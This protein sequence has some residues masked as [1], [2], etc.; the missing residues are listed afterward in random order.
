M[1]MWSE[2][3]L[4]DSEANLVRYVF[5]LDHGERFHPE[6]RPPA[7]F[8]GHILRTLQPIVIHTA[9]E[10][11]RRMAELDATNIGG[12]TV[13]NSCIYVPILRGDAANG[14]ITVGKQQAHAF[15]DSDVSLLTT[16]G[17]AMSVALENARLFDETQR[18][19]K[20]TEQRAAELAVINSI[21]EGMAA[22]LNFQAIVDL[23]GDKLR[24][25]FHTGDIGIRW[26]DAKANLIHYLYQY[27]HGVRD[28]QPPRTPSA[29]ALKILQTRQPV[30]INNPAEYAALGFG[31]TPGTDQSLSSV[32]VPILGS[33]RALGSIALENYE[34]ENAFGE[35]EVRLLTTVAASMG[36]ALE[37][38]RLFDETQRLLKETEQRAAELAVINRIQEGMAAE[39]DFQAIV[40]LVG[41]KLREVFNTGD[42][43]I[44]WYDAKSNLLHYLYQYE[45]GVRLY[46]GS[47][48]PAPGGAWFNIVQTRQPMVTNNRAEAAGMGIGVIPG[49][50]SGNS[51]VFVPI[52][53]SDRVLGLILL[54][55]YRENAFGESEVRLLSTVAASM[56]VAL[57]NARLFDE[58]KRLL[59]ETEQ[60]AAELA[61]INSIQEGLAAELD[62]QAIIDLVGDK[63]REVF[64][65]GDI[66][67]RWYDAKA[68][69]NHYLYEYEHGV[70][71]TPP[72]AAP[73]PGGLFFKVMQTRRPLVANNRAEQA[74]LGGQVMPGT[75]QG[76]S[77]VIVPILGSDR[78][79]GSIILT[80]HERENAFGEAEVRL[81][82]T[83][84]ASMGVALE[85]ARLF[86]ETQ[87]LLKETEQRNAELAIINSVQAALGGRAQ[88]P[89]NLRCGGRQDSRDLSTGRHWHPDLR[90]A[91]RP[92]PFSVLLQGWAT[93][94]H[95]IGTTGRDRNHGAC[96]AHARNARH[97]RGHAGC[98]RQIRLARARARAGKIECLRAVDHR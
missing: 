94:G 11:D 5:L 75:D 24:E 32:A 57:E 4:F 14:V 2:S 44:R 46:L 33:D 66:G 85:S 27:E 6:S 59:A 76:H 39:L 93:V 9:E 68:N 62:F 22:E 21:Q 40:D 73:P 48:P 1:R 3:D 28:Y 67:I 84:A 49:T 10:L 81:L 47:H 92:D 89:G 31:T 26:Y 74:A 71:L 20:E 16:L 91:H 53:G 96:T 69:L 90:S 17:N 98:D 64:K 56:G 54:E 45:H 80:N 12:G 34:R 83:V 95:P 8:T 37:N 82:S 72:S 97:Q 36:V 52:L 86:D 88:H 61:V 50:D 23:V 60:R 51:S 79:L 78:V 35:A 30:V 87:R 18:L 70:R 19:L 58:T 29:G 7:G 38:A 25:V 41:D 13:D 42:I 15:S 43:G 77:L 55:D 65:T 63:L